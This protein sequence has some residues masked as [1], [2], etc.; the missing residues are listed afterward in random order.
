M[1]MSI[2]LFAEHWD[3]RAPLKCKDKTFYETKRTK[4]TNPRLMGGD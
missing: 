3:S 4:N 1:L 2:T